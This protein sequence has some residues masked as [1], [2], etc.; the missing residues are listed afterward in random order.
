MLFQLVFFL[1]LEILEIIYEDNNNFF[2]QF[3]VVISITNLQVLIA[4]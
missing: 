4:E 1:W 2:L 3:I